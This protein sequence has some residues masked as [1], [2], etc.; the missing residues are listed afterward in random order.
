MFVQTR[1]V[2]QR[3]YFTALPSLMNALYIGSISEIDSVT[4]LPEQDFTQ[5]HGRYTS[6]VSDWTFYRVRNFRKATLIAGTARELGL[7][8]LRNT[9][10]EHLSKSI[11]WTAITIGCDVRFGSGTDIGRAGFYVCYTPNNGHA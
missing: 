5:K 9:R 7:F 1:G 11:H 10:G 3:L 6:H 4:C 8:F 2:T